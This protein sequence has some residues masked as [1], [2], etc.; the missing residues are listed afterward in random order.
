MSFWKTIPP[1]SLAIFLVG[2]FSTFTIIGFANDIL[3]LGSQPAPLLAWSVIVTGAFA[4]GYASAGFILTSRMWLVGVPL[5]VVQVVVMGVL[6]NR[7][8][9]LPIPAQMTAE[10]IAHLQSRLTFDGLAT[11]FAMLLGYLLSLIHI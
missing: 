8:P 4:I 9:R 10:E 6:A 2:V 7:F 11:I 5:F 1:K 3:A